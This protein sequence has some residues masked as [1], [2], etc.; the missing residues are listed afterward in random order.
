MNNI[1]D[2]QH[3][4]K[5]FQDGK[6]EQHVL[7]DINLRVEAGKTIAIMGASG[8]GKSTLL[9]LMGGLAKPSEGKVFIAGESITELS[10]KKRC[11]LRNK[12][13]GFIYQFHHLLP[14]FSLL[15]KIAM[16][17]LIQKMMIPEVHDKA[18]HLLERVG[19]KNKTH[20]RLGE[21][22]GGERQRVAV[23]RALIT[24]PLC[25]LADEP[26]GNLDQENA[27]KVL[28][29]MLELNK[30]LNTSLIIVTHDHVIA[31]QMDTL[32]YL[33][34]GELVEEIT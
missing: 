16:P 14:E 7:H 24:N 27:D 1:I 26:T 5:S 10:E 18:Q 32:L 20:R 17:L 13:L 19:L 31:K 28:T 34:K 4:K 22:S 30:D 21:I 9:H 33:R 6:S 12:T 3:V 29:L 8:S 11:A 2:C 25:V 15:E 23:A